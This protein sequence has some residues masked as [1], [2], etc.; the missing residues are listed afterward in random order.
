[1]EIGV[2]FPLDSMLL[3]SLFFPRELSRGGEAQQGGAWSFL[4]VSREGRGQCDFPSPLWMVLWKTPACS[5][6]LIQ[7]QASRPGW[8][9]CASLLALLN[10]EHVEFLLLQR[11]RKLTA[12]GRRAKPGSDAEG[13]AFGW[14]HEVPPSLFLFLSVLLCALVC[15]DCWGCPLLKHW[16]HEWIIP[17]IFRQSSYENQS[18][19]SE[20]NSRGELCA[21]WCVYFHADECLQIDEAT[22]NPI[23]GDALENK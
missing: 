10:P 1:M 15:Q 13:G 20:W 3:E 21:W 18:S 8:A 19:N 11:R 9:G 22:G 2:F 6:L 17:K 4:P 12:R 16:N 23:H 14:R 7:S 5:S